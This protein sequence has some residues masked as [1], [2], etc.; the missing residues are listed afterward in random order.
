M[1]NENLYNNDG[2]VRAW[3]DKPNISE[4]YFWTW[5]VKR[6][7]PARQAVIEEGEEPSILGSSYQIWYDNIYRVKKNYS[8]KYTWGG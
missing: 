3:Y 7:N 8:Y 5:D 2:N 6:F 1:I 4:S